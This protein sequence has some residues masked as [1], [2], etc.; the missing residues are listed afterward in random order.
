MGKARI[1]QQLVSKRVHDPSKFVQKL[2]NSV[3]TK[4]YHQRLSSKTALLSITS[5]SRITITT[6]TSRSTRVASIPYIC[7]LPA[8][9]VATQ[10]SCSDWAKKNLRT[11]H[12]IFLPA[13]C[14]KQTVLVSCE[15]LQPSGHNAAISICTPNLTFS[16]RKWLV[17]AHPEGRLGSASK[18]SLQK[19]VAKSA[20]SHAKKK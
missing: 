20:G 3:K 9:C 18:A 10:T 1:V 14:R 4:S 7:W 8:L 12:A 15:G 13:C 11:K 16:R 6:K 2:A 19:V 5:T 17:A